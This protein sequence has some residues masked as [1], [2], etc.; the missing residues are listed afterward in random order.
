MPLKV[1]RYLALVLALCLLLPGCKQNGDPSSDD[2]QSSQ[3]LTDSDTASDSKWEDL[4]TYA[5]Y[6]EM[7]AQDRSDFADSFEVPSEFF[8]WLE[9]VMEI[10]EQERKEN[11]LGQDGV[12]DMDKIDPNG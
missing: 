8:Q 12:I 4:L 9:A 1:M 3:S 7:T 5:E 11:E 6:L 2:S 10:Y